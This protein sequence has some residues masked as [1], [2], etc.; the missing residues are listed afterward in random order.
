MYPVI[1]SK[2]HRFLLRLMCSRACQ[3]LF[4]LLLCCCGGLRVGWLL[5]GIHVS[6]VMWLLSVALPGI[7]GPSVAHLLRFLRVLLLLRTYILHNMGIAMLGNEGFCD[8][9]T[10]VH[11]PPDSFQVWHT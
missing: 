4:M 11:L 2:K 5:F 9:Q 1:L 6:G 3:Q 7:G 10:C 8:A